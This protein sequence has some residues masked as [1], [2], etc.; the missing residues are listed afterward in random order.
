MSAVTPREAL[1][2]AL[3]KDMIVL[4]ATV[5]VGYI[6][7]GVGGGLASTWALRG[8]LAGVIGQ[9]MTAV[10]F[11][12]GFVAVL[13][14]LIAFIYKVIADANEAAGQSERD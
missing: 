2:Y 1:S 3:S 12:G 4:Y 5:I 14:G 10:L 9:L 8:G 13:G 11:L 7:L 6:A